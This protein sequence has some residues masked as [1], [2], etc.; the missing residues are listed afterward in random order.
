VFHDGLESTHLHGLRKKQRN[1]QARFS[2]DASVP[3]L[4]LST[5]TTGL[6]MSYVRFLKFSGQLFQSLKASDNSEKGF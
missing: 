4:L 6:L 3:P 1:T 5:Q 2:K